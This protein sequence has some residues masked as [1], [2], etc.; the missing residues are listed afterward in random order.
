MTTDEKLNDLLRRI[1]RVEYRQVEL[2]KAFLQMLEQMADTL[3]PEGWNSDG[4]GK[5]LS[6]V[7]KSQHIQKP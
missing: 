2:H 7:V 4:S 1:D 6:I 5:Q 3:E